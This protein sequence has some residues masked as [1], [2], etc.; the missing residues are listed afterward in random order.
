VAPL[1]EL[2]SN[3]AVKEATA[4]GAGPAVL[5]ILAIRRDIEAGRIIEVTVHGI[6]LSRTLN[7]VWRRRSIPKGVAQWLLEQATCPPRRSKEPPAKTCDL[8]RDGCGGMLGVAVDGETW[9]A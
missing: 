4:A 2:G 1:L 8:R 6:D 5:S 3:E 9:H 7:A